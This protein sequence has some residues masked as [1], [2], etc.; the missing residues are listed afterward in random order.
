MEN[1][2][3]KICFVV[4]C[5]LLCSINVSGQEPVD[6][7]SALP[8]SVNDTIIYVSDTTDISTIFSMQIIDSYYQHSPAKASMMSAVV[9]GLGQVYNNKYWKIPIVYLAIGISIE[10]L[11]TYNNMYNK[12]RR[13]YIDI[14]DN[15]PYTQYH[16]FLLPR[17]TNEQRL[18]LINRN[19][20]KLRTW[21]D[22]A[23]VAVFASY[24]LNIIDANVDAHLTN[25]DIDDNISLN[26][27]PNFLRNS[28]DSQKIVLSLCVSF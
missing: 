15:D 13:A 21:R 14:N 28:F 9:P 18:Q 6:S 4:G 3:W 24:V 2:K 12:Y 11:V 19:K 10:R 16:E 8:F 27:R 25:F 20:D 23:I 1:G 17:L 26:I 22:W 5:L 7:I